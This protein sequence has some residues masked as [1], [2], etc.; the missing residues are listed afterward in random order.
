MCANAL[1]AEAFLRMHD[2]TNQRQALFS[3]AFFV[4]FQ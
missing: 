4:F 2:Q 1:F 3:S